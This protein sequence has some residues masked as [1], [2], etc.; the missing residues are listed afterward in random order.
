[1]W[2]VSSL[3]DGKTIPV[4][5]QVFQLKLVHNTGI[6]FGMQLMAWLI[7]PVSLIAIS[8]LWWLRR[9]AAMEGLLTTQLRT[10]F[11]LL[12]SGGLGNLIDRIRQRY[13]VDFLD[14]SFWPTFNLADVAICVGVGLMLL[15]WPKEKPHASRPI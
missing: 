3:S 13:V 6:A 9:Q 15:C 8:A 10:A 4:V 7:V 12:L 5:G 2:A 1:M 14:L 11:A